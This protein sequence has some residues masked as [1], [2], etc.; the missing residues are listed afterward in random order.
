[1]NVKITPRFLKLNPLYFSFF[2]VF[3]LASASLAAQT[4]TDIFPTRVT[5]KS[6][7]TI[8]GSG[9]TTTTKDNIR[10]TGIDITKQTLVT[11]EVMTFEI[12]EDNGADI[13][14]S[15]TFNGGAV[16]FATGA[17]NNINYIAPKPE[18]LTN[19]KSYF[20]EEI[21]TNWDFDGDGTHFWRSDDYNSSIK[22]TWPNDKH[23]LL[24][25][26]MH[27]GPI[28]STGVDDEELTANLED[29][30]KNGPDGYV[31]SRFKAYSTNGVEGKTNGGHYILTGDL[32]DGK[33]GSDEDDTDNDLATLTE[34]AGLTIF[35][36]IIDGIN[37]LELG[38]GISNFN[39]DNSVKFYSGNGKQ[40]TFN[41]I[42]PDLLITQIAQAGGTDIYFYADEFGNVVGTPIKLSIAES[43]STKIAEW[44]LDL[45][46]FPG[47]QP[48]VSTKPNKRGFT[49][50]D[51]EDRPI[52]MIAFK[53]E[54]FDINDDPSSTGYIEDIININLLAGGTADM[55]FLAYNAGTFDIKSP[56]AN[57]LLSRF[58]CKI[59]GSSD[60]LFEVNAGVDNGSGG[61]A[62]PAT[63]A[64][65]NEILSYEWLKY[66]LPE[67]A[68]TN[69]SFLVE[70]VIDE[71]LATYKVKI[72]NDGGT[73]I[74]PVTLSQGG[75]PYTWNGSGWSS[76]YGTVAVEERGLVF[77]SDYNDDLLALDANIDLEACD[78]QV[79]SGVSVTIPPEKTLKLYGSLTVGAAIAEDVAAGISAL[80]A[81]TFTLEDS[82]SLIQT[83]TVTSNQNTDAIIVKRIAD[84]LAANDYVYWSSPVVGGTLGSIPGNATY[85]WNPTLVNTNSTVGNWVSASGIMT[86]GKG[87]IK[88]VGSS[89]VPNDR[90]I[91]T[92]IPTNGPISIPIKLTSETGSSA[93]TEGDKHWNLIG[94]PY[95]SAISAEKFLLANVG[96][97]QENTNPNNAAIEGGVYLWSHKSSAA[98][99]NN[100]PFYENFGYNYNAADYEVTNGLTSTDDNFNGNIASGQGFFVKALDDDDVIFNNAMRHKGAEGSEEAY[101]NTDFYRT[102][103]EE[104][105]SVSA[106]TEKQLLWLALTNEA[107]VATVAVIGYAEGATYGKDILYDAPHMGNNDFCLYTKLADQRIVIQGRPLPFDTEDT[108]A[109]GIAVPQNGIYKIAID[110]LKGN[111]FVD[112]AQAIYLE[113]T[114]LNL[115]HDL[116]AA[117]YGFTAVTGA[118][119]DRF[120]LRY[121]PSETL[122]V[123]ENIASETFAF[124]KNSELQVRS[125]QAISGIQIYDLNGKQIATYEPNTN[126][127]AFNANFQFA[128][129]VYL[130]VI[131]LDNDLV[132]K[133]KLMN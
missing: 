107:N 82:A 25:F 8:T 4:V 99:A 91:F 20:V 127:R 11:P 60:V 116:R 77:A 14:E 110:N 50:N 59:D 44:R 94:N 57:P 85:L 34:I 54:D 103:N 38:T 31:L 130:A 96:I 83:K 63:G 9:F 71:D 30:D 90:A 92:G 24:G 117:P 5:T 78:C 73:I 7:I 112:Q 36:V 104:V 80:P 23:E 13:T 67:P 118:V 2:A 29:A 21:Y 95:P 41:D 79:A 100:N 12:S 3:L 132:V 72:S 128:R 56:V 115:V 122:A 106:D 84:D 47:S 70:D 86:Q 40:G 114:Y 55:A 97:V 58:V 39:R 17:D 81:G 1:M 46:R 19:S 119:N 88:R 65:P 120:V 64:D 75:T 16:T 98:S 43:N 66:N 113:D 48:I 15:L 123:N 10:L 126:N 61:I 18:S 93:M 125:S 129:G 32:I 42:E 111:V 45:F 26:K 69:A 131:T 101:E 22:N 105:A 6:V 37:G 109:L 124:I 76:S 133:T 35:D 102:T 108:V 121:T 68:N 89:S 87:Y 27:D 53:L 52:R 51:N 49:S 28:F 74:L 33:V 62:T